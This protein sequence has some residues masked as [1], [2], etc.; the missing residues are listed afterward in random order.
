MGDGTREILVSAF[1][2][3]GRHFKEEGDLAAI[4]ELTARLGAEV[5]DTVAD[6][7]VHTR[8]NWLEARAGV[9]FYNEGHVIWFLWF[10]ANRVIR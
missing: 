1:L 6:S 7:V 9:F 10:L 5:N 8:W 3:L 4:W 2:A